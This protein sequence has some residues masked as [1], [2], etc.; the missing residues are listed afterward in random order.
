MSTSKVCI[1]DYSY[2]DI[3]NQQISVGLLWDFSWQTVEN[4]L[5]F[6]RWNLKKVLVLVLSLAMMLSIMVVGAGA[7]TDS[8]KIDGPHQEAVEIATQLNIINGYPD[9][10]FKPEGHITRAEM[11]K[12]ICVALNGGKEP[13]TAV[14]AE[15]SFEDIQGNWAEGFI[16]YCFAKGIVAGKSDTIFDPNGDVTGAE[17]AKML[18]VALGYNAEAEKYVGADWD[19]YVNVQANQDGLYVDL[20]DIETK[21]PLTR[22][23]AAQMIWNALQAFTVE[24]TTNVDRTDGSIND[25][26]AK[27]DVTLFWETYRGY[28]DGAQM[29]GFEYN[30]DTG[31]WTY[32]LDVAYPY[33]DKQVGKD[34]ILANAQLEFKTTTDYTA[35]LGHDVQC[36]FNIDDRNSTYKAN[37]GTAYGIYNDG[38]V[39]KATACFG[40]VDLKAKNPDTVKIGDETFRI[41]DRVYA[42]P[43]ATAPGTYDNLPVFEFR[44]G[45]DFRDYTVFTNGQTNGFLTLGQIDAMGIYEAQKFTA[46][47]EDNNGK[48][49]FLITTPFSFLKVENMN[50]T[51]IQLMG[52]FV[53]TAVPGQ[54]LLERSSPKRWLSDQVSMYDGLAKGDYVK[55]TAAAN[56]ATDVDLLEKPDSVFSGSISKADGRDVTISSNDYTI[57]NDS[58]YTG[59][60]TVV[61]ASKK[62]NDLTNAMEINGYIFR[63]EGLH[64]TSFDDY[65]IVT[66]VAT[67]SFGT[68]QVKL[69][70]TNGE[71]RTVATDTDYTGYEGQLVEWWIKDGEYNL[72]MVNNLEEPGDEY[73]MSDVISQVGK[74]SNSNS[75]IGSLV[76]RD[77]KTAD[78]NNDAV[79]FAKYLKDNG[80]VAWKVIT[81]KQLKTNPV[82]NF[83][84]SPVTSDPFVTYPNTMVL[85]IKDAPKSDKY[86]AEF[87]YIDLTANGVITSKDYYGY[88]TGTGT[89]DNGYKTVDLW[90]VDG[91]K[92][93][94]YADFNIPVYSSDGTQAIDPDQEEVIEDGVAIRYK[95]DA[96]ETQITE[97][98]GWYD[99][100]GEYMSGSY[101]QRSVDVISTDSSYNTTYYAS[102]IAITDL[103][104]NDPNDKFAFVQFNS[105][106]A[107]DATT[108]ILSP[109]NSFFDIDDADTLFVDID[110]DKGYASGELG[111]ATRDIAGNYESNAFILYEPDGTVDLLVYFV[112]GE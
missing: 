64:R 79:V 8:D 44:T 4:Y 91:A 92:T 20:L 72:T 35:L 11:S 31:K 94:T 74:I 21:D 69:L 61:A 106:G 39:E 9:G 28:K 111:T 59:K 85:A 58:F 96:S 99:V 100:D 78:I 13:A 37:K 76:G 34:K 75:N 57:V 102:T 53:D 10:S 63:V 24:K 45:V 112:D 86:H 38:S 73:S 48:I 110:E 43:N 55:Y 67:D 80:N 103:P 26:Y 81:G 109:D 88:V 47:D 95:T 68:N 71:T 51:K 52:A 18:L 12:I 62:G 49:D 84:A 15:P 87:V 25:T 46:V 77:G 16:E 40:D 54:V 2:K 5:Y 66:G 30:K 97:I 19:L 7:F 107:P 108:T 93:L 41:N 32:Y 89:D 105:A 27:T 33:L 1:C 29:V 17:A 90:T 42:G 50:G 56:T 36:I 22:E 23:H 14:K 65:A 6:V 104:S 98:R 101:G 83:K 82:G 3:E 70:F 60:G